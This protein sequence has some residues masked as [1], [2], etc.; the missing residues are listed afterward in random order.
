MIVY[1]DTGFFIDYFSKRSMVAVNL[2]TKSRRGRTVEQIQQ[3]SESIMK[4]SK[5]NQL[6]T[7][8]ITALEYS[9][10]TYDE[11]KKFSSGLADIDIENIMKTKPKQLF[12]TRD[13]R[14]KILNW[15]H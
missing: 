10:N 14:R 15:F 2:R 5:S 11:L 7:S 8:A 9:D 4:K 3:E 1:L 12:S 6:I 13:V